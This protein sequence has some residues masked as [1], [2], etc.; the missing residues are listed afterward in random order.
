MAD[1]YDYLDWRGDIP[2]SF[3]PFNEIDSLILTWLAYTDLDGVVPEHCEPMKIA[4]VRDHYFSMHAKEEVLARDT[5]T[6]DAGILLEILA[7]SQRFQN[8]KIADFMND[9]D[10]SQGIQMAAVTFYPGD[11]TAYIAFRGTDDSIVGWKEDFDFSYMTETPGQKKAV[12]YLNERF[13]KGHQKLRVGGHSKGG[14]FAV[15][16]S[17][18]AKKSIR[19]RIQT[20]YSNDGPGFLHAITDSKEYQEIRDRIVSVI[21]ESSMVG[22]LLDNDVEHQVIRS[23]SSGKYQHDARTWMVKRNHFVP[24]EE[25]TPLSIFFDAAIQGWLAGLSDEEKKL[26]V[27]TLFG[28]MENSAESM[29]DFSKNKVRSLAAIIK[30][31]RQLDAKKQAELMTIIRAFLESS[32]TAFSDELR[33]VLNQLMDRLEKVLPKQQTAKN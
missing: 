18:F 29:S 3:D 9:V 21:P 12:E 7:D 8:M 11:G 6:G 5:F 22:I 2:F 13:A 31:V 24:A 15:Y 32:N 17:A 10:P 27:E 1:F 20:I 16:A 19:K 23:S 26:F 28:A 4:D 14:N 30:A 33:D 25:R